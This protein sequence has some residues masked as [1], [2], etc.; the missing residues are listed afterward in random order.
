MRGDNEFEALS[1]NPAVV[2]KKMVTEEYFVPIFLRPALEY[3]AR[4]ER[5]LPRT[6]I[7]IKTADLQY[8]PRKTAYSHIVRRALGGWGHVPE[9][10]K[11]FVQER[12][13]RE[14]MRVADK[15]C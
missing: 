15:K 5:N 6:D 12:I 7:Q 2:T 9:T 11:E 4:N 14:Q 3:D 13:D 1:F 8:I 10:S